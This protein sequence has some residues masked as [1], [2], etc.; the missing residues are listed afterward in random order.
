M[1]YDANVLRRASQRLEDQSR[2]RR[3]RTDRL[4][5]EAY[6]R[7]PRLE[8]L[9]RRLRGT[10]A[11]LVAAALRQGGDPEGESGASAGA[12]RPAGRAGPARGRAG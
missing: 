9:D 6:E 7:E 5:L 11:G 10:M 3:E 8:Q 12:G 4:R 1:P 2:Q